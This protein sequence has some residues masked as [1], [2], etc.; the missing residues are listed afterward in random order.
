M[1]F[2]I[3]PQSL[4]RPDQ[5]NFSISNTTQDNMADT[6][7]KIV[8]EVP[9]AQEGEVEEPKVTEVAATTEEAAAAPVAEES[10][11]GPAEVEASETE[12]AVEE[13]TEAPVEAE[14]SE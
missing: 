14:P 3:P 4:A 13:S 1:E 8:E 9:A 7:Q 10:A 12:T 11:E 2:R 5:S 6:E